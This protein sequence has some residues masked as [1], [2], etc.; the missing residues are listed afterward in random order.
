MMIRG[1]FLVLVVL[2]FSSFSYAESID[3]PV[4]SI[5]YNEQALTKEL[6]GKTKEEV[7]KI[8]GTPAVKKPCEGC[9]ENLEY[10]WYNLPKA[11]IFVHFKDDRI[12]NISVLTED[13]RSKEL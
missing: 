1:F 6:K 10:W 13:K 4:K 5:I 11:S 12:Y 9:D 8:L 3:K 7:I 2:Y